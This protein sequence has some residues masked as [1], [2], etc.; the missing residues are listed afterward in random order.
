MNY[1]S[2]QRLMKNKYALSTV[3]TTLIILVIS[4]L[5]A[6][7]VT[8]FAINVVSTRV[9][10]ESLSLSDAHIWLNSGAAAGAPAYSQASL[11]VINTGG[12]DVVITKITVRGQDNAWTSWATGPTDSQFLV[13]NIT[14]SPIQTDMYFQPT[15]AI[16]TT[17]PSA[18]AVTPQ[19]FLL[20]GGTAIAPAGF[21]FSYA[22]SDLVLKSGYT[23][24]VYIVNPDSITINDIGLTVS[25]TLY[26]AQAMY[27]QECNVQAYT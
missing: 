24:L 26:T 12:R 10:E 21:A 5:L 19:Q 7:V 2:F 17:D 4:V 9:Q 1:N 8:Y 11:K 16:P 18:G 20:T 6:S 22:T 15:M 13:Y 3:V 27:Y 23:L 25:I 14:N